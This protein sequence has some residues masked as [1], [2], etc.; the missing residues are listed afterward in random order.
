MLEGAE[1]KA[2]E[3]GLHM[4]IAICDEGG[5]LLAFHRMEGAK[6][7]SI[8]VAIGKAFTAGASGLPTAT[9]HDVAGPGTDSFGIHVSNSGRFM[10]FGGGLPIE[11]G[12]ERLGGIGVSSGT[13]EEDTA[14]AQA[15][16]DALCAAT[17]QK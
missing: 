17:G 4:D 7:T 11:V 2:K 12:G 1:Q 16:I 8:E 6:I 9:Y 15:G 13:V 5:N 3:I 10:I 14:V